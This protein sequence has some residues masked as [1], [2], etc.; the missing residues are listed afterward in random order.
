MSVPNGR[1]V[2]LGS[3]LVD[4]AIDV[5]NMPDRGGDVYG[6][7]SRTEVGGGFN[8]AA[9]VVRQGIECIYAGPHGNGRN[10]DLVRDGLI[11]EGIEI[12]TRRRED[13]DTGFCIAIIEPDAERT[14][15]T[16]AGVETQFRRAELDRLTLRGGDIIAVSGYDLAFDETGEVLADWMESIT[17]VLPG[18]PP[19]FV[20]V[21]PGPLI[22]EIPS[23]VLDTVL[24]GTALLTL[25]QREARMLTSMPRASGTGLIDAIR[26][27]PAMPN[28]AIVVV[29]EGADGCIAAGGELGSESIR[30]SAP[31]VVAV[32][33]TGAGDA[34]TGVLLAEL[35]RGGSLEFALGAANR[36]AAISVTRRGSATAPHRHELVE[37]VQP[38]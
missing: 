1:V 10:G 22:M 6:S 5:P 38:R 14:F 21:D 16:M 2:S 15:V 4:I 34:H 17:A 33:T 35:A 31:H 29:R 11:A 26:R 32:D 9:A 13:G 24:G 36:A 8:L 37:S 25:N 30:V 18:S 23:S 20:A 19:R 3:I 7:A 27:H 28:D 12:G